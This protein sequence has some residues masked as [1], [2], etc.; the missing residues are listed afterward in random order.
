MFEVLG[1]MAV[2]W[3]WLIVALW[4]VAVV[5]SLPLLPRL[6]SALQAGGF[7]SARTE[8]AQARTLM[9]RELGQSPSSLL[10]LYQSESLA[11]TDDA[12]QAAV[13][14]SLER[15]RLLPHVTEVILPDS[16]LG[17][18]SPDQ[19]T[20]YAIVGLDLP[21]E[22]AQRV[23]PA[24]EAALLP[25]EELTIAV[26]GGPVSYRDIEVASQQDLRRA[27]VIAFPIALVALLLV[28]GSAVAAI[29]PLAVGG[30]GVALVLATLYLAAQATDVSIFALER[31]CGGVMAT[32]SAPSRERW[33]RRA[34]RSSSPDS[35][36]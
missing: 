22:E 13:A 33:R 16:S 25:Q 12:F 28:F 5:A 11:A 4:I 17:M 10:V 19:S 30:A 31:S 29:V 2:R 24:F 3:R 26:A 32:C 20:A 36:C 7:S 23:V 15:V 9:Q 8:A 6:P 14:R 34:G 27:E 21:S 18:I 35:R 1:R